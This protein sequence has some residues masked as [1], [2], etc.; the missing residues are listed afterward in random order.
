MRT[1]M[2]LLNMDERQRLA[3]FMANRGTL[4][5]VGAVWLGMIGW[6]LVHNRMP[7]FLLV[8]VPVFA[9]LR[10]GLFALYSSRPLTAATDGGGR[11]RSLQVRILAAALLAVAI[12][13]PVYT[14]EGLSEGGSR[15]ASPLSLV[16]DDALVVIPLALTYLWP[17]PLLLLGRRASRPGLQIALQ[18][19]EPVLAVLSCVLILWIPQLVFATEPL[20]FLLIIPVEAQPAWGC[21]LAV[22]ANILYLVGWLASYLRPTAVQEP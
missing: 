12:F 20:F 1:E 16:G 15:S 10:A 4:V 19:L 6:E 21:Y 14:I 3:W 5:A 7:T 22:G 13:L 9:L 11:D 8:M 18:W 2:D 17:L